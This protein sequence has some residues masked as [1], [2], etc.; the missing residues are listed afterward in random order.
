MAKKTPW[1]PGNVKPVHIGVYERDMTHGGRWSYWNGAFWCGWG[2]SREVAYHNGQCG[3]LSNTQEAR[4]RGLVRRVR[5]T[6]K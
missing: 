6:A 3:F 2:A 4:W 1:F 5:G